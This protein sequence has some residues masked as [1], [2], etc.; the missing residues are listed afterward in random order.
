MKS[1]LPGG[2]PLNKRWIIA[3]LIRSGV[4]DDE[5]F[6][7]PLGARTFEAPR[8]IGRSSLLPALLK[9]AKRCAF[10]MI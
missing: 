5:R 1:I 7:T 6:P 9:N 10:C 2:T 8:N 4:Q 3:R